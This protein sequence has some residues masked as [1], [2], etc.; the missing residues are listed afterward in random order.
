MYLTYNEAK[1]VVAERFIR[2][3]KNK[4]FN[5]MTAI[6]K[7]VHFDVL[8]DIVNKYN[9][10]VHR[11]INMKPI[12]VMDDYYAEYNGI[13]FNE[14]PSM[15]LHSNKKNPE[16]KVGDKVRISK[17]KNIFAKDYTPNW[18]EEVLLLIKL[19]IQFLGLMLLVISIVKKLLKVF[20]KKNCKKQIKKNLE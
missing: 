5:H 13:A 15:E 7:N 3:L 16:V 10:T 6:S 19:K 11:I 8:D 12:E 2:T 20:M 1:S 14:D 18:P 17:Y 4:I 9:N